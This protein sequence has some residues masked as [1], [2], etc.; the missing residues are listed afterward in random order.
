MVAILKT[1]ILNG[2]CIGL[3]KWVNLRAVE[4]PALLLSSHSPSSSQ[5]SDASVK[6]AAL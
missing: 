3:G 1:E 6:L 2:G 4:L 5:F